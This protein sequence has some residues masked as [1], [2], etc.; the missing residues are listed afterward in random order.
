MFIFEEYGAFKPHFNIVKLR[1]SGIYI[2]F[3]ISAQ[4]HRFLVLV[5]TATARLF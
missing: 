1:F 3:F 2:I 5:R 4:K